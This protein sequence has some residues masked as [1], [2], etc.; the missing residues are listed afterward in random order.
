MR[1]EHDTRDK[2]VCAW[3]P[4]R[5]EDI[6]APFYVI[7]KETTNPKMIKDIV[8]EECLRPINRRPPLTPAVLRTRTYSV[9]DDLR[10]R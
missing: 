2:E 4:C 6:K 8:N 7:A 3:H 5:I 10:N 9:P 1:V